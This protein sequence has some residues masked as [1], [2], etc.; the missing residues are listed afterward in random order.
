[1]VVSVVIRVR[2]AAEDLRRCLKSL[3]LQ[4]LPGLDRY[5]LV[6]VDNDSSDCSRAV[7]NEYGAKIV[8]I[9]Q[10]EFS[11]GRALNR[12][13][14]HTKG[15]YVVIMSADVEAANQEWLGHM[16]RPLEDPRVVAVYGRQIP[17]A[18]APLDEISRL[19]RAF[20]DV[21]PQIDSSTG[22]RAENGS[23]LYLSNACALVR[24]S[25]WE[26][27]QFDEAI[28]SGE[29]HVW[30][31]QQLREGFYY[32]YAASA[33]AY[34]S[35]REPLTRAAYRL[36][37]Y[38]REHMNRQGKRPWLGSLLYAAGSHSKCRLKNMVTY[39]APFRQRAEGLL[40]LPLE[41]IVLLSVGALEGIG[42]SRRKVRALMWG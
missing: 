26:R 37:E 10:E 3:R 9:S 2:N 42:V 27:S 30:M 22:A 1:M 18:D 39:K 32:A 31:E 36:W 28:D 21:S 41:V 11:W 20:P 35:H 19:A 16:L 5:D 17:R 7:A 34:H 4:D 13:L 40:T 8:D 15:E 38:H 24:R 25:G 12:G 6:V 29:E 14:E 23:L 33:I